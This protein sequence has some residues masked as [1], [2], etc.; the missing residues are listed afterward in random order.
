MTE[1]DRLI[2]KLNEAH[3]QKEEMNRG[4]SKTFGK[5]L[6]EAQYKKDKALSD[7][8][9]R[10]N[11]HFIYEIIQNAEDSTYSKNRKAELEFNLLKNGVLVLSNQDGFNDDNVRSICVMASGVKTANKDQF[12]GEKGLG[13]R[14][15]FKITRTPCIASNG[16]KFY[17]DRDQSYEKPFLLNNYK[18]SL[19]DEFT[20]YPN[21]AIFLPYDINNDEIAELETDFRHKIQA[22]LIL[23]L[24]KLNAIS[25]SHNSQKSML[26]ER[27][28]GKSENFEVATL[29]DGKNKNTFYIVR[30]AIVVSHI[31]EEKRKNI[32]E[33]E[34]VLAYPK[35][36]EEASNNVFAFLPTE[37][38]SRLNFT[39]QADFLLNT[40]REEIL[41]SSEWNK[42]IFKEIKIFFLE[43]IYKFQVHS[44]LKYHYLQY[45]LQTVKSNNKFIDNFYSEMIN[46][47]K[48]KKIILGDD[49]NWYYP[50]QAIIIEDASIETKYLRLLY[51]RDV[52]QINS[53]FELDN[54]F[55][56]KFSINKISKEV[57]IEK[58]CS[59][60]DNTDFDKLDRTTVLALTLV[61]AKSLSTDSRARSYERELYIRVK[62]SL[63]IIPKYSSKK[64]FYLHDSI[65]ISSEYKPDIL[66]E[67]WFN[68]DDYMFE[69]F[70]FLSNDYLIE[71]DKSLEFFI[72]KVIDEQ[73]EN[74]NQKTIDFCFKYPG[75]LANYLTTNIKLNYVKILQFLMENQ[76][77]NIEKISRVKF[78]YLETNNFVDGKMEKVYFSNDSDSDLPTLHPSIIEIINQDIA[79]RDF[80]SKV[81]NVQEADVITI[82]MNEDLNW[83]R[84]NKL[85]RSKANDEKL[86]K[87]TKNIIMHFESFT[88][89]QK[90][91]IKNKMCFISSN[92]RDKYLQAKD[93]YL[94]NLISQVVFGK[95]SIEYYLKDKSFF[96][97]IEDD[98]NAMLA[99][100][101]EALIKE[102][103][104][105]FSFSVLIKSLDINNFIKFTKEELTFQASI[106]LF[107]LLCDSLEESSNSF[108][109][110]EQ[111]KLYSHQLKPTQIKDLFLMQLGKTNIDYL[112]TNYS[113]I[114]DRVKKYFAAPAKKP[115]LLIEYLENINDFQ[116]ALNVYRYL[117][118]ITQEAQLRTQNRTAESF[119]ITT[120]KKEFK[121]KRLIYDS[122]SKNYLASEVVWKEEKSTTNKL[123]LSKIYPDE[124]KDFF[125]HK[126]EVA[127]TRDI[128]EIIDD[129]K[130]I[131]EK[132]EPYFK[133]L[134]DLNDLICDDNE[135]SKYKKSYP[136]STFEDA[137]EFIMFKERIF[138]LD[139]GERNKE[140]EKFYFNDQNLE[141][142]EELK[143]K[144]FSVNSSFPI[145]YFSKLVDCLQIERLSKLKSMFHT[146]GNHKLFPIHHYRD[147]LHLA[148]DLLFTKFADAY[149][150][151][152]ERSEQLSSI[153]CL[154]KVVLCP[155]LE[156]FIEVDG[157]QILR[158]IE[159]ELSDNVLYC[160]DE[161]SLFLFI[162]QSIGSISDKDIKDFYSEVLKSKKPKDK[163]YKDEEI[164]T[165]KDFTL[166]IT[167]DSIEEDDEFLLNDVE[168]FDDDYE[169]TNIDSTEPTISSRSAE[170]DREERKK[171]VAQQIQSYNKSTS[172]PNTEISPVTIFNH[173][174]LLQKQKEK[175]T[176]QRKIN[177]EKIAA[178][179]KIPLKIK[180]SPSI[181]FGDD[182]TKEYFKSKEFYSGQCQICGFTFQTIKNF[183]YCERFT[184]PD[185]KK[186]KTQ[187]EIIEV[188]NS[189]CLCARCHS[190]VKN[191]DFESVFLKQQIIDELRATNYNFEKFKDDIKCL[192]I[193][194]IPKV[195]EI[196]VECDDMYALDIRINNEDKKIYFTEE[197]LLYF[198]E[199]LH[200]DSI[201]VL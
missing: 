187:S 108:P 154:Q 120:L 25:I 57:L 35:E 180:M 3:S 100:C 153:N 171:S 195:F 134:V 53:K 31:E 107:E 24:K 8:A 169:V 70:N 191:G 111:L 121:A 182:E 66:I 128:R 81:F 54:F 198:F 46:E 124:L 150:K 9:Y 56:E 47:I 94:N 200:D 183:N 85:S 48:N 69:N 151:L 144:V 175:R 36:I 131:K 16:Y 160:K 82:I 15:V 190:I 197:H 126:V 50:N 184:I 20:Q 44:K 109:E 1:Q 179:S 192:E 102:F 133:L 97:V 83:I 173:E 5:D 14:S 127:Q 129:I 113:V 119:S 23:F 123:V 114:P 199:F 71:D 158:P 138:R 21:T 17:F 135:V 27:E 103:F 181:R 6:N 64:C 67:N 63:P 73:K 170:E 33:R 189:F 49:E 132:S 75:L 141:I 32:R 162:A 146:G 13:F 159:F 115:N 7:D 40:S 76:E 96:D 55:I 163:Y 2:Q 41:E 167:I 116:E 130:L 147:M 176:K 95:T 87:I 30:K 99:N 84:K 98:Y 140:K 139:N 11:A 104:K 194:D 110:I 149:K 186:T 22:K 185:L 125:V 58:I 105:S 174:E 106:D 19:P 80:F 60:F 122:S 28:N 92:Q 101:K 156:S 34:I 137:K 168:S 42:N 12:I 145:D 18:N 166:E 72:R 193:T 188:G 142:P 177:F 4:F 52:I 77:D 43:N 62:K 172:I 29:K 196:H 161:K 178:K 148:Y 45:C 51:G 65:Y 61:I 152:K 26:I 89:E 165:K 155:F 78:L 143:N 93:I 59:Y 201:E 117:N 74:K 79:Y 38:N 112:H 68:V 91:E 10:N 86:L 118:Q 90:E 88:K 164:Q 37:I 157:I 39:I 136:D